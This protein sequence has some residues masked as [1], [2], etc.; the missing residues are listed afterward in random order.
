M[1][2]FRHWLTS[3]PI[4][5]PTKTT[6][7]IWKAKIFSA[8][9]HLRPWHPHLTSAEGNWGRKCLQSGI[10][11]YRP[12]EY[13]AVVWIIT[14]MISAIRSSTLLVMKQ[15]LITWALKI[16]DRKKPTGT[17]TN[18]NE[19]A[20]KLFDIPCKYRFLTIF[21]FHLISTF[22]LRQLYRIYIIDFNIAM[23]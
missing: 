10:T 3:G 7:Y 11:L 9:S 18:P 20:A 1:K 19:E 21:S 12:V 6:R 13:L 16:L 8:W 22:S 2:T 17:S 15:A 4:S 5:S 23:I 14:E